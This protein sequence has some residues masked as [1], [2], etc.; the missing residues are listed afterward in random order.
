MYNSTSPKTP[1]ERFEL[2]LTN[3]RRAFKFNDMRKYLIVRLIFTSKLI[4]LF[5]RF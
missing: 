5:L 2:S 3:N 4:L 1:I